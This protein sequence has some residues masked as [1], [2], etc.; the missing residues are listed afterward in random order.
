MVYLLQNEARKG[1]E[2]KSDK[3]DDQENG[4][5]MKWFRCKG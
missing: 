4:F 5:Q 3:N 1:W 2:A